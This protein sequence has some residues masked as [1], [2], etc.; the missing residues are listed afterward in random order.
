MDGPPAGSNLLVAAHPLARPGE[1]RGRL[2]RDG[3]LPKGFGMG[4]V[5]KK[6]ISF[7]TLVL[8]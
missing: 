8:T 6:L 3:W 4:S 2:A 1:R 7:F 5:Q